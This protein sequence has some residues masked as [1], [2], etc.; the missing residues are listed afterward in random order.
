MLSPVWVKKESM[1]N[2]ISISHKTAPIAVRS[3]ISLEGKE[4]SF[5]EMLKEKNVREC[6]VLSTCNRLEI[7]YTCTAQKDMAELLCS[8]TDTDIS[9][10][11]PFINYFSGRDAVRHLIRVSC[12]VDSMV[13]GEDE[14]S[15]QVKE[16]YER[17][18]ALFMTGF[19]LN[20]VFQTALQA[21]KSI[22]TETGLSSTPVS[23]ATLA[24]NEAAAFREGPLSVLVL[25]VTGKTG[26]SVAKNLLSKR[27]D[28]TVTGTFRTHPS[29]SGR[30]EYLPYLPDARMNERL[31]LINFRDRYEH[32]ADHDVIISATSSPH[33]TLS[34]DKVQNCLYERRK[35]LFIDLAVPT[36]ID[37]RIGNLSFVKLLDI[38]HFRILSEKNNQ[39]KKRQAGCAMKSADE[40][41]DEIM[42]ELYL[43]DT[44]SILPQI[45][46]AVEDKGV[47]KLIYSVRELTDA[48]GARN[49][50]D[51]LENYVKEQEK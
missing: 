26:S 19:E 20:T 37:R 42:K 8:F 3:R 28:I 7:Y 11:L 44:V 49:I 22:K 33:H 31:R 34:L 27:E 15:R 5:L 1:M 45:R 16:A 43:H 6:V 25:G 47:E 38:D 39:R 50:R 9:S 30:E 10:T 29:F 24:S 40:W 18:R 36:D 32:L 35:Y 13:V 51:W 2:I 4:E 46:R 48:E 12:G 21:A 23:V 41:T 14:I 17:A